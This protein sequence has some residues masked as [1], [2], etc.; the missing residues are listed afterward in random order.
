MAN[1]TGH[2]RNIEK[3][4]QL[5]AFV[6][7][8]GEEY[9][10]TNPNI[11]LTALNA[12]L[13]AAR[14]AVDGVTDSIAPYKTAINERETAF[15]PLRKLITRA[16]NYYASTGTE[17]NN[18]ADAQTYSRKIQGRRA[19]PKIID[20]PN[21]PEDESLQSISAAQLSYSQLV[22]HLDNLIE[23]FNNDSL[24]EPNEDELKITALEALS[25]ELKAKNDAVAPAYAPL[26]NARISRN[27]ELY[28][29]KSGL[30]ELADLVKKYVKARFGA[31]SEQYAQVKGL[32]FTKR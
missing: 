21:T 10:P 12:K 11:S 18:L 22:E 29:D 3:F 5:I 31:D 25:T 24:Y 30:V 27:V 28:K 1:E 19:T 23:I 8:Y 17:E 13:T 20:D 7:A 9:E 32:K 6:T 4:Q 16:I 26:S 2:A 14:D 15:Q